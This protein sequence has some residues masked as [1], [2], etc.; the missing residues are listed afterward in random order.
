MIKFLR[1]TILIFAFAMSPALAAN[2]PF[3]QANFDL[4]LK[5][6]APVVLHIHATWC[7]T[8][9]AQQAVLDE[10]MPMSE[11]KGL[12]VLRADFDNETKLLRTYKVRNQS[13]FVVF[14]NGKEVTRSTGE[15]DKARI[16]EL[17]KKAL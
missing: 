7:P 1:H 16:A 5:Q 8:C 13:T 17:L 14:R 4:L 10:L 11:F 2:I 15:T 9:K 6:G 3:E 12:S